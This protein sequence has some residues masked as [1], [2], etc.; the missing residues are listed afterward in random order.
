MRSLDPTFR[1]MTLAGLLVLSSACVFH[2]LGDLPPFQSADQGMDMPNTNNG[3]DMGEDADPDLLD[4]PPDSEDMTPD[5]PEDMPP[6]LPED[7]TPDVPEDMPEDM[8]PDVPEDMPPDMPG[9]PSGTICIT[10]NPATPVCNPVEQTGCMVG[11]E[12]KIFFDI[13]QAM[14]V[15]GCFSSMS[16]NLQEGETCNPA[17]Q[18]AECAPELACVVNVC[19]QICRIHDAYGCDPDGANPAC[20]N[21]YSQSGFGTCW[22]AC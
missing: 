17:S 11:F 14:L 15:T 7:M 13:P 21:E 9:I 22:P 18:P 2:E 10:K 19:R 4:M 12:C 6:D 5:L 16:G 3:V 8:T 1:M 20:R